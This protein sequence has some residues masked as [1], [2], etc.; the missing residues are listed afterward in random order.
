MREYLVQHRSHHYPSL[1]RRWSAVARE[2]NLVFR[3]YG[4][5]DGYWLYYARSKRRPG[6]PRPTVYLSAGTHGDE[7]GSTEG[8]LHWAETR[9][10]QLAQ[11]DVMIFPCLNPWG[12]VNNTRYTK[13]GSDLNRSFHQKDHP[14]VSA[15]EKVL[16]GRHFGL[17]LCLHEDYDAQGLYA[18]EVWARNEESWAEELVAQA[19]IVIPPDPRPSIDGRRTRA[20]VIR[21][22]TFPERVYQMMPESIFLFGTYT[23]RSYTVETPSEFSLHDRMQTHADFISVAVNK[24]LRTTQ[25]SK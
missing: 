4:Q 19:G 25:S 9:S 23:N 20:G 5:A 22:R 15:L 6:G 10:D 11:V 8:L 14:T 18:Y 13:D 21:R 12:L 24:L 3:R 1:I 7:P 16:E 17:S 2:Q